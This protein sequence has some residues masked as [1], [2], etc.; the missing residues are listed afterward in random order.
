VQ[1]QFLLV[2]RDLVE[3][4]FESRLVKTSYSPIGKGRPD[5]PERRLQGGSKFYNLLPP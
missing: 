3:Y 1:V 4:G 5:R 2:G